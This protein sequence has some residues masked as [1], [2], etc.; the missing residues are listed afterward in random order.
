[1]S[2]APCLPQVIPRAV[3]QSRSAALSG[4]KLA[5]QVPPPP[6]LVHPTCGKSFY[7][8]KHT[9]PCTFIVIANVPPVGVFLWL[10]TL[11]S[12]VEPRWMRET[13]SPRHN[14]A[15]DDEYIRW[16]FD[17]WWVFLRLLHPKMFAEV[18]ECVEQSR[19]FDLFVLYAKLP[20]G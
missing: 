10:P 2:T 11:G 3:P 17:I 12:G 13:N 16:L 18:H 20:A 8:T 1:M 6:I 9:K 14:L 19:V 7:L 15:R 4:V 5:Q